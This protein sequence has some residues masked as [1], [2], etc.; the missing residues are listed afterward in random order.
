MMAGQ[1]GKQSLQLQRDGDASSGNATRL[2]DVG[3][4]AATDAPPAY[5]E[6]H[7]QFQLSQ[8][9]FAAGA[10]VTDDGRVNININQT[11]S[12][13]TDLLIPAL[14]TQT[15]PQEKITDLPPSYIPPSLGG[16]PGQ[17]PPPKL[18]VVVQIVGSRGDVQPF[19]ALGKVLKDTYG[20]RV[21]IATHPTFKGFVEENGLE[22]FSIG[23]DPAELMAFMVKH[24][25]LM[26]PFEAIKDGEVKKRRMGIEEILL[27]C[28]RSCIETGDGSGPP[29]QMHKPN[30]PLDERFFVGSQGHQ[31][32]V[33]DAI[34]ANPPS[35]AH[36]HIAEKLG[37]PLHMMFTMPW[38]PTKAFP[39]PLA[40]I[41]SSNA[42][43]VMTNYVSYTLVE[44]M[45]W[46]GLGDVIN[47]FRLK[48]LDLEPLSLIWAPGLL[49]RL[50]IPTTY[51]WSPALIPKPNDWNP[52][53]SIS[54]F[55]FL[56]LASSY[57]P[58]P[59]LAAFLA[60][61]PPPVYIGFGSIV[62]DDPNALTKMIFEAV[63]KT[64]VRALVSKGWGGIGADSIG[65][66]DGVFML[67]NCP[68]DWL[69]QHV[70]CVVHHGGAGTTAAGIKLGKPTV[71]VPFF[72]D[73]PF[74]GSMI[75]RAGAGPEPVPYKKLDAESLAAAIRKA[76]EPATL[77]K[78]K[79]LGEKIREE[80]G[81]DVGGKS[82]HDFLDT[83]S[84]RCSLAPSR[85]AVWR[86]RRSKVKLSAFAA[87]V[88]LEKNMLEQS[89]LKLYR[90]KEYTTEGQPWDPISAVTAALIGDV[91][92]IAMTISDVPRELFKSRK[93]VPGTPG[94]P[95]ADG[96][97]QTDTASI[98]TSTTAVASSASTSAVSIPNLT[99]SG[100]EHEK[101]GNASEEHIGASGAR[102][103]G[104][105]HSAT[106][107]RTP[108]VQHQNNSGQEANRTRS[109]SPGVTVQTAIDTG[110]GV[111]RIVDAGFKT[112]MNFCL[113]LARGFRNAPR[114]YNDD[115]VRAPERVTDLGSGLKVAG[116]EFGLG[117]YD[118]ISGL[119]TQ[120][121]K[122]AQK[123][124]SVGA[125]KGF[126]KGI[127]GIVLKPAAAFWSIPAYTMQGVNAE[128][129]T[130]WSKSW[131]NY[132]VASRLAQ[133]R[134]DLA[135]SSYQER[136]D[137]TLRWSCKN[138][139]LKGYFQLKHKSKDSQNGA[140]SPSAIGSASPGIVS[141]SSVPPAAGPSS[142]AE[143]PKTGFWH[144]RKLSFEKRKELHAQREAW[145]RG[146][147]GGGGSASTA[148]P[149]QANFEDED[150]ERAIRESVKQTSNGDPEEDVRIEQAIRQSVSE[151]HRLEN[152]SEKASLKYP[153]P[154]V[155][156]VA[157]QSS[158]DISDEQYQ[159]LIEEAVR[160]SLQSHNRAC[161]SHNNSKAVDGGGDDD[162]QLRLAIKQSME[163]GQT[164][165]YGGGETDE[166]LKRA[167]YESET[168]HR[169]Q[170]R[171]D[172]AARTEEEVVLEYIKKQSLAE[173]EYAR[174]GKGAAGSPPVT[175]EDEEHDED[176]KRALE[177]SL[178]MSSG[179]PGGS[180]GQ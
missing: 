127:G 122:G 92:T 35:F 121:L 19:V 64:G 36:I 60:D 40:N 25:G 66:P 116:K 86:V 1:E 102:S 52:E 133:G 134:Q 148:A 74:W 51:C 97:P 38:S 103:P 166:D 137:I 90:A 153:E 93:K 88:L 108:E 22:F 16:L 94:T 70:S 173:G 104:S 143:P 79:E 17:A 160:Q 43:E 132:I 141:S 129:R 150:L 34:I 31:P 15:L 126:G 98:A 68:H 128:I 174:K 152:N 37:I 69:F 89:D 87:A 50:R 75:A 26:V 169:E 4:S 163:H 13:F 80:Q 21:R 49:A 45:T 111:A 10:A 84:L 65:I 138:E 161:S 39:H 61:G 147:A 101:K 99:L 67:G 145:K 106:A 156:A 27:G 76:L 6:H 115:S 131:Q 140:R 146:Q 114:L 71:V 12:R 149:P 23:G 180:S 130:I 178:K 30:E 135:N 155:T 32:F 120:P 2:V 157:A 9:G 46:Q 41:Q 159:A 20:H 29:P 167:L 44:M 172:A 18:N 154:A 170:Q 28:W 112:P 62:V 7:D 91:G 110:K 14:R 176:L 136:E 171:R 117:L 63:T 177:E 139:E 164:I 113:G 162:E 85:V 165:S 73:Q 81:C 144:T 107:A 83:D 78:A 118:G 175:R 53:I 96:K 124:G 47:R 72:G 24:P 151:M 142:L 82:F 8:A 100:P 158:D 3:D 56:N 33:A 105:P 54:G 58:E 123:E 119:I 125:I 109:Q 57:T 5:S 48:T 55:Y 59:D 77:A 95:S 179:R 42:T 168:A 11:S